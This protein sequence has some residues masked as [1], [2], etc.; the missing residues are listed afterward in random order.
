MPWSME[1]IDLHPTLIDATLDRIEVACTVDL[2]ARDAADLP[3]AAAVRVHLFPRG[4]GEV[5]AAILGRVH[6]S[7]DREDDGVRA[8]HITF[9]APPPGR[10][11][12]VMSWTDTDG[13]AHREAIAWPGS[14]DGLVRID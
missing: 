14:A 6:P 11:Q 13:L 8:Y 5:R 2:E 10:Y 3:A 1:P 12:L 4:E 9:A 7:D